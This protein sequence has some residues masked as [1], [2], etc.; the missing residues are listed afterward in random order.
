L[1][2]VSA[3]VPLVHEYRGNTLD[4]IHFGHIAIVDEKSQI[5]YGAGDPCATVFYRSAAKPIQV[6]PT[7]Q[8]GLDSEYGLTDEETVIFAASHTG[9]NFHIAVLENILSK[10]GLRED[11]LVMKPTAPSNS[12]ANEERISHGLPRRKL[13]HNC[14]GKHTALMLLQR[15]LGGKTEDYWKLDS[16]AQLE[17]IEAIKTFGETDRV[18]TGVD[19][20]GVPVFAVGLKHI[21]VSFKNLARPAAIRDEALARTAERFT[22][23]IHRYPL[24]T[25]GTGRICAHLNQDPNIIAKGGVNGVYGLGLKNEGFGVAFKI[26]DGTEQV[27]PIIIMDILR[28]LGCLS[29]ETEKRLEELNPSVILNDNKTPVGRR[30]TVFAVKFRC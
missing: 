4:L 16:P 9:E 29:P 11:M 25:S 28:T 1:I 20:C 26:T 23:R 5:I 15:K 19:G 10:A 18:E 3:P 17:V 24:M 12:K 30:E 8:R 21:A 2:Y 7:I 6:L 27:W 22:P 13:Y 14:S